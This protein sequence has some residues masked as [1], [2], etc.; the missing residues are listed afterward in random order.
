MDPDHRC[1]KWTGLSAACTPSTHTWS[2]NYYMLSALKKSMSYRTYFYAL[3][4]C[5]IRL[6]ILMQQCVSSILILQL[7]ES[8]VRMTGAS[9]NQL[10]A[11][12]GDM[13]LHLQPNQ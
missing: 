5:I 10:N 7:V 13:W 6:V 12:N 3:Y 1:L 8:I 11:E 4:D 9:F 2:D